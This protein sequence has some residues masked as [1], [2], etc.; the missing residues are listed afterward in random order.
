MKRT[1]SLLPILLSSFWLQTGTADA[2][3]EITRELADRYETMLIGSPRPGTAFDRVVEWYSTEGGGLEVLEKRWEEAAAKPGTSQQ[4]FQIIQGLLAERLRQPDRARE[5]YRKALAAGD[6][7]QAARLL[8]A[9]E[10][11]EGDFPAALK[12]YEQALASETLAPVDRMELMRSL[13]LLHQR[14]FDD[15][16]ALGVWREAIQRFPEDLYVLEEAGEAFIAAGRYDEARTTLTLLRDRSEHDPFRRIA[17]SLRLARTAELDGKTDEAVAIYEKALEETSEG[18]WIARE[19]RGRIEELFRRKDDLPGLLVYYERRTAAAPLDHQAFAAKGAV[20]QELGREE[21]AAASLR[22]A[23]EL[24]PGNTGLRIALIRQLGRMQRHDEAL[25]EAK[26]VAR[27]DDAPLEALLLL[28]QLQWKAFETGGKPE[29]RQAALATWQRIA[30]E[31]SAD[32]ARIAQLAELLAAR[33]LADEAGAQWRRIVA[34]QPEAADAR[35]RL[36]GL[37]EKKGD[38][39]AAQE[40]VAGLVAPGREAAADYLALARAQERMEWTEAA[41]ATARRGAELFPRDYDLLQLAWRQ[42]FDAK[43]RKAIDQYFPQVYHASPNEFFAEEAVRRYVASIETDAVQAALRNREARLKEHPGQG[44]DAVV[45]FHLALSAKE[46]A[47]AG[48]ALAAL[49]AESNPVRTAR[50][51]AAFAEAFGTAEEQVA[52]LK[53]VA[54]ADPR[55]AGESLRAAARIEAN[56]GRSAEGLQLLE[57]LIERSPADASLYL[58]YTDLATQA[59]KYEE[60]TRR[61]RDA[62]RYVE[63]PTALR[64]QLSSLLTLQGLSGE[65]AQVLQEAFEG[66]KNESRRLEIFRQQIQHALQSGG[67]E[68]LVASLREKQAKEE[69]GARYG[70]YLAEI[71]L[72]QND[73]LSA[74][75]ELSRSLGHSPDN[76]AAVERL[77]DLA[78]RGGDAEEGL[79]LSRRLVALDPSP[80]RRAALLARQIQSGD[81][82]AVEAELA[83]VRPEIVK[84][85]AAWS[86]VLAAMLNAG[87]EEACDPLLDEIAASATDPSLRIEIAEL[88]MRQGKFADAARE[89]WTALEAADLQ[90]AIA[91]VMPP[92][93]DDEQAA[94]DQFQALTQLYYEARN[95]LQQLQA[96]RSSFGFGRWMNS[97]ATTRGTPEERASLRAIF[98]LAHLAEAGD[99][100]AAFHRELR[101]L[102]EKKEVERRWCL[103]LLSML[104]DQEGVHQLIVRQGNDPR[105]DPATDRMI[106]GRFRNSDDPTVLPAIGKIVERVEKNDPLVA[107]RQAVLKA[108]SAH[109]ANR[110]P[111]APAPSPEV[112][113]FEQLQNHPGRRRDNFTAETELIQL[114]TLLG[115]TE[116]GVQWLEEA[117]K[118]AAQKGQSGAMGRNLQARFQSARF[119]LLRKMMADGHPRAGAF[120]ETCLA[121]G[122]DLRKAALYPWMSIGRFFG[123]GSP[124]LQGGGDLV[125][126]DAQFPYPFFRHA[127]RIYP[128]ASNG[129]EPE[130]WFADR[131]TGEQLDLYHVGLFYC[132]WSSGRQEEAIRSLE[133]IHEA[134]PTPRSAALLLEAYEATRE[135][136]KALGVIDLAA[137]QDQ[138]TASVRAVRAI[139]LLRADHQLEAA[140]EQAAQL[141][142][143]R[144]DPMLRQVLTSELQQLGVPATAFAQLQP[145][146]AVSRRQTAAN[147]S[148]TI[149]LQVQ[150]LIAQKKEAQAEKI[151]RQ[152]LDAPLPTVA[153]HNR[154]NLR[155]YLLQL[156]ANLKRVDALESELQDRLAKDAGDTDAA[157]RLFEIIVHNRGE[158]VAGQ[159]WL[160]AIGRH[161]ERFSNARYLFFLIQR[162]GDFHEKGVELFTTLLRRSPGLLS[163]SG[164]ELEEIIG[165]SS[166]GAAGAGLAKA[167]VEM[168]DAAFGSLFFRKRLQGQPSQSQTL[169]LLTEQAMAAGEPELA[170]ALLRRDRPRALRELQAGFPS[171]L[172]LAELELGEGRKKEAAETL[173]AIFAAKALNAGDASNAF[174]SVLVNLMHQSLSNGNSLETLKKLSRLAGEA[175]VL[176]DLLASG[177]KEGMPVPPGPSPVLLIRTYAGVPGFE[178]EWHDLISNPHTQ[179]RSFPIVLEAIRILAPGKE[180]EKWVVSLISKIDTTQTQGYDGLGYL[181]EVLPLLAPYRDRPEVGQHLEGVVKMVLSQPGRQLTFRQE[182]PAA[183]EQLLK[184]RFTTLARSLLDASAAERVGNNYRAELFAGIEARLRASEKGEGKAQLQA[185]A[186]PAGKK[187]LK[188]RWN[189]VLALDMP[190]SSGSRSSRNWEQ[191]ESAVPE[192]ERP[193]ELEIVA[194]PNPARLQRLAKI[195]RPKATG[196]I[197][198]DVSVPLGIVQLRWKE[199]D[200]SIVYGPLLPYV[201]GTGLMEPTGSSPKKAN[202]PDAGTL[203][204][205]QPGPAGG[206]TAATYRGTVFSNEKEVVLGEARLEKGPGV[207]VLTGWVKGPQGEDRFPTLLV[208]TSGK[209]EPE[210]TERLYVQRSSPGQWAHLFKFWSEGEGSGSGLAMAREERLATVAVQLPIRHRHPGGNEAEGSW[211]GVQLIRLPVHDPAAKAREAV[212]EAQAAAG[213]KEY[214]AAVEHFLKAFKENPGAVL[215]SG[216]PQ[217]IEIFRQANRLPDLFKLFSEVALYLP[218]PLRNGSPAFRHFSTIDA[219]LAEAFKADAPPEAGAWLRQL[220]GIELT[221]GAG[222]LV[223][224]RLLE[225]Q[226]RSHPDQVTA[227]RRLEVLGWGAEKID[228][229]RIKD[230][231]R[232]HQSR[233]ETSFLLEFLALA[234]QHGKEL[235]MLEYLDRHPVAPNLLASQK[236]LQAFL[237]PASD[238]ARAMAYWKEAL[239]LR[240][241]GQNSGAI[242]TSVDR[243]FFA[244]LAATDLPPGD[245]MAAVQLWLNAP[246]IHH[247]DPHEKIVREILH[248]ARQVAASHKEEYHSRWADAEVAALKRPD[249]QSDVG[250]FRELV[251]YYFAQKQ[252]ERVEELLE[253]AGKKSSLGSGELQRELNLLRQRVALAQGNLENAWPLVWLGLPDDASTHGYPVHWQWNTRN[254]NPERDQ[255]DAAVTVPSEA[256]VETLETQQAVEL[257]FGEMPSSMERIHR[258]EGT[259]AAGSATVTLPAPNGFLRAVA[260]VGDRRVP[261][262]MVP[263]ISGRRVF[264]ES[265]SDLQAMLTSGINPFA[266]SFLSDAGKA[267]DGS[268]AIRI[269]TESERRQ[270]RY[271]GPEFPYK[272]GAFYVSRGWFRRAGAGTLTAATQFR[273]VK[274][275]RRHKLNMTL[276]D[277]Y[278]SPGQWIFFSR[279]VPALPKHTFWIPYR[280]VET[281][282]PR[283]WSMAG[284]TEVA[285]WELI[286]VEGWKYGEWITEL[287]LLREKNEA[288]KDAPLPERALELAAIEPLTALDYHGDWLLRRSTPSAEDGAALLDL[289]R[290]A[291][292][293]EAN[294]L[295]GKPKMGRIFGHLSRLIDRSEFPLALRLDAAL[296]ALEQE[297]R[298]NT[299]Q[300]LGF[301]RQWLETVQPDARAQTRAKLLSAITQKLA[302]PKKAGAYLGEAIAPRL[303]REGRPA[304]EWLTVVT[305]LDDEAL[306]RRMHGDL[307]DGSKVKGDTFKRLFAA[308][309]L[310]TCLPG[311]AIGDTSWKER[312]ER[313][314]IA[315]EKSESPATFMFWPMLLGERLAAM[316]PGQESHR[317]ALLYLAAQGWERVRKSEI[318]T[319]ADLDTVVA[320]GSNLIA[321]AARDDATARGAMES[322]TRML[323]K[324]AKHHDEASLRRLFELLEKLRASGHQAESDALFKTAEAE[325]KKSPSIRTLYSEYLKASTP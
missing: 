127:F 297:R 123:S 172:R 74:R 155:Q 143:R 60:A 323:A 275:P 45:L 129:P 144:L 263:V 29:E 157:L 260:I 276:S 305:L 22:K 256:V 202:A 237:T 293:A 243:A 151:I 197:E 78:D 140:R 295:F 177:A 282:A 118:L 290:V 152:A 181:A 43:D 255:F 254:I 294:P 31:G 284:G 89:L 301:Q 134:D 9:L 168:D 2:E 269:G 119:S 15:E 278:E 203:T 186:F 289:F 24:A 63:E 183:L 236:L 147:S 71:Y 55:L 175:G 216:M 266:A 36:A 88:R 41:R 92:P 299:V 27:P 50:A 164:L 6:P 40:I 325:V 311:A 264:P 23:A 112:L 66:E 212:R 218:D 287:A 226:A 220:S 163:S 14:A 110:A 67:L 148:E 201:V 249:A 25:A 38:S 135:T 42:A 208:R 242:P 234:Q 126:G 91:A 224:T 7:A 103:P 124:L 105:P 292:A 267:P 117:E 244:R 26:E 324:A 169:L 178:K 233:S 313:A 73:Y 308:L 58:L 106:A 132:R 75:E 271:I 321:L 190:E 300:V 302:D 47:V 309:A 265:G 161:P 312:V 262:P 194:G 20:E 307:S 87:M 62:I 162:R 128:Q 166:D 261:G 8:A 61:L 142:K 304:N 235:E 138:E 231:W 4:A 259:A 113:T 84:D 111:G 199:R 54:T 149:R 223:A 170:L 76:V 48:R 28:G 215:Q 253:L 130:K 64:L 188:V 219:L 120:F 192:K 125:V 39:G 204:P 200:G 86:P 5:W 174:R 96:S 195:S 272:P 298:L 247:S 285:G 258:A 16:K 167:V 53:A 69:G 94:V 187:R 252:W 56:A 165:L 210:R 133:A 68:D 273:P 72:L 156:L 139:R 1:F 32:V 280:E 104:K 109:S 189:T 65:A 90:G 115:K 191:E 198:A 206:N 95:T 232:N 146:R 85:P 102:L 315:T 227:A 213:K 159:R 283:L 225:E 316:Q 176:D 185:A 150:Q 37:Y 107:F 214:A 77:L 239:A 184:H 303:F 268:P 205:G 93:R 319:S 13:A 248:R 296:L 207:L 17:A 228:E 79:R 153:D 251:G 230:L 171:L 18:S 240:Q 318:K 193:V 288:E 257:F 100:T 82:A 286:E 114:A 131:A 108:L 21:E 51:A 180:G 101:A 10:T 34:L 136:S 222:V 179:W 322:L 320:A 221:D 310:E 274:E 314:F 154:F 211:D 11:T 116:L 57:Q 279:A 145:Y 99:E 209:Q 238:P 44:S 33:D 270:L 19:T 317:E 182:Y 121:P 49:E 277:R 281:L 30:P 141:A 83:M 52:A 217:W 196:A 173:K 59:G 35:V 306:L 12:A 80:A 160:E 137:L 70:V 291:L 98:L 3:T 250:R 246:G 46:E 81:A 229:E 122:S 241:S 245:L 158:N 97:G